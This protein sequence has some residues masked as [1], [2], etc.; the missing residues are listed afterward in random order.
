MTVRRKPIYHASLGLL[1]D[2][3]ISKDPG[4]SAHPEGDMIFVLSQ[5]PNTLL[6][7]QRVGLLYTNYKYR[8]QN[9]WDVWLHRNI[10]SLHKYSKGNICKVTSI[11]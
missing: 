10:F 8:E 2:E 6:E 3:G 7:I 11:Q 1:S 4:Q 9:T 5:R